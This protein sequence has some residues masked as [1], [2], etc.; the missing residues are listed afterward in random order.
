MTFKSSVK[1]FLLHAYVVLHWLIA[2]SPFFE[3]ACLNKNIGLKCAL[4]LSYFYVLVEAILSSIS[5]PHLY[6]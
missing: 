5:I 2:L 3:L 6:H 1:F 4:S